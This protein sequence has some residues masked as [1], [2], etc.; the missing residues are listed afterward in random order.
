MR[1]PGSMQS[2]TN[3]WRLTAGPSLIIRI[4]IRPMPAPSAWAAMTTHAFLAVCRPDA[5]S[6]SPPTK[7]SSTSTHPLNRSRSGRTIARLRR[8]GPAAWVA[9][10]AGLGYETAWRG[11]IAGSSHTT[12]PETTSPAA[13]ACPGKWSRC[14]RALAS[15]TG[16]LKQ[17]ISNHDR[18][19]RLTAWALKSVRPSQTHQIRPTAFLR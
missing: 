16:A 7:V 4:L 11:C 18:V 6:S 15:T 8:T 14:S 5:P 2:S 10:G 12:S 17:S 9:A 19:R 3:E 13:S 1:L